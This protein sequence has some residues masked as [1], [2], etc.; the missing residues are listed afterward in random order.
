MLNWDMSRYIIILRSKEQ[1]YNTIYSREKRL[2][3]EY[4][5]YIRIN[6]IIYLNTS[7]F[8]Y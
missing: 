8:L 1:Y 4:I 5:H 6:T 7:N 3:S 2:P